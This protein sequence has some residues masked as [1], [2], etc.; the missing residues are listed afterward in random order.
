MLAWADHKVGYVI[1][2]D[3]ADLRPQFRQIIFL[4][5][6][7]THQNFALVRVVKAVQQLDDR[8]LARSVAANQGD[9]LTRLNREADIFA[10]PVRSCPD[11]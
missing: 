1:L 3:Y 8:R 4:D 11:R 9:C 10:G 7:P 2:E 5:V 6:A